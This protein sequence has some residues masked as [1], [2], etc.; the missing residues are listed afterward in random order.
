[1][2]RG[3]VDVLLSDREATTSDPSIMVIC[4]L[5]SPF[6][7]S[8]GGHADEVGSNISFTILTSIILPPTL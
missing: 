5:L 1:M 7:P 8:N 4:L 2:L 3:I 6:Y